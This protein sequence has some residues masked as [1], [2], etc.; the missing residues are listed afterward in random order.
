MVPNGLSD[1]AC[2]ALCWMLWV[3]ITLPLS[4]DHERLYAFIET[5]RGRPY[6]RSLFSLVGKLGKGMLSSA[7]DAV[8]DDVQVLMSHNTTHGESSLSHV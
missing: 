6:E 2:V 1:G 7:P 4:E 3:S 8:P 5:V